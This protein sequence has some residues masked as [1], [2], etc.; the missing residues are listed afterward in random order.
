M[1]NP[2]TTCFGCLAAAA[3][4]VAAVPQVT[5]TLHLVAAGVAAAAGAAFAFF[6]K[7][8]DK[9]APPS[10]KVLLAGASLGLLLILTGCTIAGFGA[11]AVIPSIGD[12][13]VQIAGGTIGNRPNTNAI[14]ITVT[15]SP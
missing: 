6:A 15:N 11:H 14:P 5:G 1:K 9:V 13:S 7:D 12:Y 4:A 3:G 8:A 2:Y 10:T